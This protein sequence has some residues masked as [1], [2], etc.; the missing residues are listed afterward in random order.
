MNEMEA[1]G[2]M[3]QMGCPELLK[4][5]LA[6]AYLHLK[7]KLISRMFYFNVA[8]YAFF[9]LM[10]TAMNV[11]MSKMNQCDSDYQVMNCS[12]AGYNKL[13]TNNF[14]QVI[15]AFLESDESG[16]KE[17]GQA[18]LVFYALT[19]LGLLFLGLREAVQ[20]LTTGLKTYLQSKENILELVIIVTTMLTLICLFISRNVAI[21]LSAWGLFFSS[22]GYSPLEYS[23][24]PPRLPYLS[25]PFPGIPSTTSVFS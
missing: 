25:P 14:G 11:I 12:K 8:L 13:D 10:F 4:H 20:V 22:P 3:V 21:H 23:L 24:V 19:A 16:A 18:F 6:E 1:H 7:W 9:V 15:Q 5:P 17:L 2:Q